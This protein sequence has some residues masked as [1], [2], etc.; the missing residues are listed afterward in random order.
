[1]Q[2]Q[3]FMYC[4]FIRHSVF[5]IGGL[6]RLYA[7]AA[8]LLAAAG[9]LAGVLRGLDAGRQNVALAKAMD[10]GQMKLFRAWLRRLFGRWHILKWSRLL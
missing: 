2:L 4:P 8:A 9:A 7:A 5:A 1:M 3:F 10:L 6:S